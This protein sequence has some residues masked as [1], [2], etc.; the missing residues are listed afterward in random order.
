MVRGGHLPKKNFQDVRLEWN[1]IGIAFA[2][3]LWNLK[4]IMKK[5][6]WSAPT[7]ELTEVTRPKANLRYQH[8]KVWTIV[9]ILQLVHTPTLRHCRNK[10]FYLQ[11]QTF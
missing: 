1:I 8:E 7:H 11:S 5:C 4:H 6:L 2:S 10:L 3:F 9:K